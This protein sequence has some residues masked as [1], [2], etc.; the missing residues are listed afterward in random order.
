MN[1]QNA[2]KSKVP[3]INCQGSKWHFDIK[4][5]EFRI[6]IFLCSFVL[7]LATITKQVLVY[8]NVVLNIPFINYCLLLIRSNNQVKWQHYEVYKCG[9]TL[10]QRLFFILSGSILTFG[11]KRHWKNFSFMSYFYKRYVLVNIIVIRI[12]KSIWRL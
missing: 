12:N 8:K 2:I 3:H 11:R 6:Y 10:N 9:T 7:Y 1:E 5:N 4:S